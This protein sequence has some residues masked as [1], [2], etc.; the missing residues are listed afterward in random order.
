MELIALVSRN[1][2]LIEKFCTL[3]RVPIRKNITC[4]WCREKRMILRFMAHRSKWCHHHGFL[5]QSEIIVPIVLDG[6]TN[7]CKMRDT[8]QPK[9]LFVINVMLTDIIRHTVD[10]PMGVENHL[11]LTSK[12]YLWLNNNKFSILDANSRTCESSYRE[13]NRPRCSNCHNHLDEEGTIATF[14]Y[15]KA[16]LQTW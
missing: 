3:V 10:C 6:L 11:S 8:R 7:R 1:S 4:S 12:V 5:A 13:P 15:F 14:A 2:P 9:I 16:I